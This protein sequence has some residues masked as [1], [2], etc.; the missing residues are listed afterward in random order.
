M[1]SMRYPHILSTFYLRALPIYM[2]DILMFRF[3]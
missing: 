3:S 2:H 1:V